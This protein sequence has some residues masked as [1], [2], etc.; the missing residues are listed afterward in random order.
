M[1]SSPSIVT[2]LAKYEKKMIPRSTE[3]IM[4]SRSAALFLH[5]PAALAPGNI[6]RAAAAELYASDNSTIPE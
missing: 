6:T 1:D 5:S 3:K 2:A 4:K